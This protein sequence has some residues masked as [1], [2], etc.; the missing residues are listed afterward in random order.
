MFCPEHNR[1]ATLLGIYDD[2]DTGN[3]IAQWECPEG[4]SWEQPTTQQIIMSIGWG[5]QWRQ[6]RD[7][8]IDNL[9]G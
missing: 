7:Q 5:H 4:H 2:E 1:Q 8:I 9:Y 6:R 3:E